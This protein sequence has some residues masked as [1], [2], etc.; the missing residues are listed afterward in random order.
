MSKANLYL[1]IC[2][3]NGRMSGEFCVHEYQQSSCLDSVCI[4]G[5]FEGNCTS[6]I[7]FYLVASAE[8][9]LSCTGI[10]QTSPEQKQLF[11]FKYLLAVS[12]KLRG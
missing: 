10:P 12:P 7:V 2:L 8:W 3:M 9:V 5:H 6:H 1:A 4:I 11:K